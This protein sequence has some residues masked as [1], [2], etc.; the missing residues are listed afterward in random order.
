MIDLT[1]ER[2]NLS[3]DAAS[4]QEHRA[5]PIAR[6]AAE[7]LASRFDEKWLVKERLPTSV[8]VEALEVPAIQLDLPRM[9]DEQAADA[10]ADAIVDAL[11]VKL[12]VTGRRV[13]T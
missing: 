4:G 12:G 6:R 3:L 10:I 9:T 7:I 2:M 1:I 11:A 5:R 13:G 8:N